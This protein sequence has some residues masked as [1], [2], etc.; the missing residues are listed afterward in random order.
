MK[1][2]NIDKAIKKMFGELDK[3]VGF[4][5]TPEFDELSEYAINEFQNNMDIVMEQALKYKLLGSDTKVSVSN[6]TATFEGSDYNEE[7]LK[8]MVDDVLNC[9]L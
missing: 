1:N 2:K 6:S 8:Q 5:K 7:E 9:K 4:N 3:D